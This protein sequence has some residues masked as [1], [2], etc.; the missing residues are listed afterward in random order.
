MAASGI[1]FSVRPGE[2]LAIV[3]ESG[4]DEST[5]AMSLLGLLPVNRTRNR[6]SVA[7]GQ[8]NW[9]RQRRLREVR[10]KKIAAVIFQEPMTTLNP[11]YGWLPRSPRHFRFITGG[12]TKRA[13]AKKR[14]LELLEMV[15]LRTQKA[16]NS[17]PHQL[18]GGQRQRAMI[19]QSIS[20]DPLLLVRMNP[21]LHWTSPCRPEILELLRNLNSA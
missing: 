10:G 13:Q 7:R 4:S 20:C 5:S 14:S 15:E 17:Y 2:V 12:M 18:S 6:I 1:S 16:F 19:A 21:R 3:G 8:L 9:C 11:V